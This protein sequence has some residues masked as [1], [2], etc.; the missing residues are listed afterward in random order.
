MQLK[1]RV[2]KEHDVTAAVV[3]IARRAQHVEHLGAQQRHRVTGEQ[4]RVAT[5]VPKRHRW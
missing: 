4:R 1:K 2:E 5:R 3:D